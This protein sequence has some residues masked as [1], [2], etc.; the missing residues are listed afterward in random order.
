MVSPTL[1]AVMLEVLLI[2]QLVLAALPKAVSPTQAVVILLLL[3]ALLMLAVLARAVSQ[4]L[5]AVMLEVL[6]IAQLVLA[7]PPRR[8]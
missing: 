1:A 2:A 3:T 5:A 7:A 4:T 8:P 6:L